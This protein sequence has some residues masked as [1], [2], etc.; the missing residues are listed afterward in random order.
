M[1]QAP[2]RGAAEDPVC[3]A[4][5]RGHVGTAEHGGPGSALQLGLPSGGGCAEVVRLTRKQ[6]ERVVER[7][8]D[9][10]LCAKGLP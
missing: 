7:V 8:S 6:L 4:A 5:L 1:C 3:H 10:G 9:L 2:A